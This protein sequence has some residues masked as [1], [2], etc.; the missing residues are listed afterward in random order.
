[1][2]FGG[3]G[4]LQLGLE[5]SVLRLLYRGSLWLVVL[6]W[7]RRSYEDWAGGIGSAFL[8]SIEGVETPW[9]TYSQP[10]WVNNKLSPAGLFELVVGGVVFMHGGGLEETARP[11]SPHVFVC[12]DCEPHSRKLQCGGSARAVWHGT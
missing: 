9:T 3:G 11:T 12:V 10:A 4:L 7:Q 5:P 6:I 2:N 8:C 1:M